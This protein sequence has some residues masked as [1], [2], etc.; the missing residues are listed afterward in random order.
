MNRVIHMVYGVI[1][2]ILETTLLISRLLTF[3]RKS[4]GSAG[5]QIFFLT[6]NLRLVSKNFS[7]E[8]S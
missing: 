6:N 4:G 7:S 2:F 8:E 3:V 5:S 1:Y